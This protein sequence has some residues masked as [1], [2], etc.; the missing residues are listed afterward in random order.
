MILCLVAH[1]RVHVSG[2]VFGNVS[3]SVLSLMVRAKTHK[4]TESIPPLGRIDLMTTAGGPNQWG[5]VKGTL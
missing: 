4:H 2:G 5:R 3:D 1:V